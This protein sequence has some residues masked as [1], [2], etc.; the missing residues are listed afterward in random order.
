MIEKYYSIVF[1]GSLIFLSGTILFC[2]IRAIIGPRMLDRIIAINMIG[3]KSSVLIAILAY[4]FKKNYL[5][6]ICL[7]YAMLSFLTIVVFT[8][9]LVKERLEQGEELDKISK[10]EGAK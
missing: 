3:V 10:G 1:I 9:L 7:V 2:L 5:L 6:D 4:N 8:K